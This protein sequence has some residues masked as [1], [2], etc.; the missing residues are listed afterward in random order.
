M[1][2]YSSIRNLYK[3]KDSITSN[4]L[5]IAEW[6][7]NKYS[8][9]EK[10]GLYKGNNNSVYQNGSGGE[11]SSTSSQIILGKNR[12]VYN[13][14]GKYFTKLDSKSLNY[15]TL[16]SVFEPNRPDPGIIHLQKFSNIIFTNQYK[17]INVS[18]LSTA[19]ARFYPVSENSQYDYFNSAKI[20]Y[21]DE[22]NNIRR[23]VSN[24]DTYGISNVNPFV[25]YENEIFCN[26]IVVKVQNHVCLP[27]EFSIDILVDFNSDPAINDLKWVKAY[28]SSNSADFSTGVLEIYYNNGSWSKTISRMDDFDELIS[29]N[30]TQ[31][32]KIRGIRFN[33][34]KLDPLYPNIKAKLSLELIE[35]SP[36]L[37]ADVT[38]YVSQFNI[39]SSIGDST[40][41]GLP[42]GAVVSGA[43]AIDLSNED[44]QFLFAS[45]LNTSKMLNEDVQF[46]F[47]QKVYVPADNQTY[48]IPL[49]VM[50]SSDWNIG[51]DYSISV[52][53]ED[54]MKFLKQTSAPDLII[55]S[56]AALSSIIL[57]I[58]DNSGI[59]GLEFKKSS[60]SLKHDKE[61][62][63]LKNF[64]CKKE[65]TVA[66]V[67]EQLAVATQCS[68]FY[69]ASGKL[70]VLTKERLAQN[71]I[72]EESSSTEININPDNNKYV[73]YNNAWFNYGGN[74]ANLPQGTT[75]DSTKSAYYGF[76]VL[77]NHNPPPQAPG[78]DFWMILDEDWV[79]NDK[80]YSYINN[81]TA[82]V[83]SLSQEKISPITDGDIT[84]HFY[85]P[86]KIPLAGT[87]ATNQRKIYD[88]LAIDQFP[89]NS[90]ALSNFDFGTT[91]LWRPS[92]DNSAAFGA[93]NILK[94]INSTRLKDLYGENKTY[95]AYNEDD[96]VRMM[97]LD[98]DR[99]TEQYRQSFIIYLDVNEGLTFPEYESF[100]LIDNEYIKYRGKLY[101]VAGIGGIF[102]YKII[103]TEEEFIQL[104]ASL[105]KGD[106]LIFRGL[107]IDV[108]FRNI[109]KSDDKYEYKV[110]G[111]GRAQFSS[112][113]AK[114]FAILENNDDIT[115]EK[116]FKLTLGERPN[117]DTPGKL[118][119]TIRFN[120]LEKNR[121]K[122]V[123]KALNTLPKSTLSTYL[124]FLKISGPTSPQS[125]RDA[126]QLLISASSSKSTFD[127]L[128]RINKQVDKSIPKIPD[129]E[130]P[131][132]FDAERGF[133]DFVYLQGEKSIYGQKITLPF[134]PNFISTRMRLFSPRKKIFD[135]QQIMSTNSSI[136]GIGF[137]INDQGEGYYLEVE[138]LGSG[139]DTVESRAIDKNLRFYK[140]YLAKNDDG[141]MVYTPEVLLL[142]KVGAFTVFD[143]SAEIIKGSDQ[144]L[145]P[146]FEL[147]IE[148]RQYKNAMIYTIFYG[149]TEIGS[150]TEKIGEALGVN[151]KNI[152]LFVRNDSQAIY[153]YVM[154][155][156]KPYVGDEGTYFRGRQVFERKMDQGIIPVN[157]SFL[158]KDD[159][160]ILFYFNDFGRLAR[161]VKQYD[162]RFPVPSL[163]SRLIDVSEIN[164]KYVIKKYIP[165]SFGAKIVVAN[166]SSGAITLDS[167]DKN[168]LYIVGIALEELNS[169][170]V[171][172]KQ[173]YGDSDENDENYEDK[174]RKS[175]R[176]QNIAIYG[177][178]TFSLDSQFIQTQYQ[179]TSLMRWI[180]KYCN[181]QRL[182][183]SMEIF[184]NPLLE[185]GDKIK[186]FDKSRGYYIN[187]SMFGEKTFVVSSISRS[188]TPSGPSMQI[189]IFEVGEK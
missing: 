25:V 65:Q 109:G 80:E 90:L 13:E 138:S 175:E 54:K 22:E 113:A 180:L 59:T 38:S 76:T 45:I 167:N 93:A 182:K 75:I 151:S 72:K 36:R 169:G 123:K 131:K 129:A 143:T 78:T 5:I 139:K 67:L 12:I 100:I 61:D 162:I 20:L 134:A 49:G 159:N 14:N 43:G 47:Y 115:P 140:I 186:I 9:I 15:S 83:M 95:I 66:E 85:G 158:F 34:N 166:I 64:F 44:G 91:I 74:I 81:Y 42:V 27:K 46:T 150:Y 7:M 118:E 92:D 164:Q 144:T 8:I 178:Q 37:E 62:T 154:A 146:V 60:D 160:N 104:K 56:Y 117:Y 98:K 128:E 122:S 52:S 3:A 163:S 111:D 168:P 10:C 96:A 26:K 94:D 185:L 32:K 70:N 121:Y 137:G 86:K 107:V 171:T 30:P 156:A 87:L 28:T 55:S 23:G 157:K 57:M 147:D 97:Y 142:S 21:V 99:S 82:N 174:L 141:K 31:F 1:L 68:I 183:L 58:L 39:Q 18:R 132:K 79:Q 88:Q 120:F 153:E 110:I 16:T 73:W 181:R 103:F 50:F 114:H 155:A 152:F 189:T 89:M 130:N 165:T 84:Y 40:T 145:D 33:L 48:N 176:E 71:V 184:E 148:I 53:L 173:I 24:L 170:V 119:S 124:G 177:K 4:N 112:A 102:G 188:I 136:A 2:N 135:N 149:D 35:I 69:D 187:N 41:F 172:A 105:D 116:T 19:S 127:K 126:L 17:N 161:Q 179:A 11:Y 106:S 101:Y 6:N 29:N 77:V 133:H 63:L 108:K 51:E 125:D